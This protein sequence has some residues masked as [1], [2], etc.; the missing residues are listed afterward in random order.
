MSLESLHETSEARSWV[1][2]TQ[3]KS[4]RI[5]YFTDDPDYQPPMQG[6]WYY[7]SPFEGTL[8]ESMTLRNCWRW[9]FN[10]MEF[11]DAGLP[12]PAKRDASLLQGNK[13]ALLEL[14][15]QR[16]DAIR[17]PLEPSSLAGADLRAHKLA[18]ARAVLNHGSSEVLLLSE[19]AAAH[20]CSVDEMARRVTEHDRRRTEVL[21]RT[22]VQ[23]EA[24]AAAIQRA[25]T[26]QE[27][28]TLRARIVDEV[29]A[30]QAEQK[31]HSPENTTPEKLKKPLD[32]GEL[33]NEQL[34]LRV[35]L[36]NRINDLRRPYMSQYVLDDYVLGR[37]VEIAAAVQRAGGALPP[38][39]DG[40]LLLSHAAARG[41]R[42]VEAAQ[43][44]LGESRD[45][46]SA[47]VM[48]EQMKDAMLARIVSAGTL[49]DIRE[50]GRAIERLALSDR[51]VQAV[52][53]SKEIA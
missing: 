37:K 9:R 45:I 28:M 32:A 13:Q 41:Q 42:L 36:R 23:R 12:K 47:L 19:V 44:V 10:G 30:E 39:L 40:T 24:I 53:A 26:Q 21:L 8:P 43:D 15:S 2:V 38:G 29:A 27:L 14:L 3:V 48:T 5:V 25:T 17:R 31:P 52:E 51:A 16:I 6:D 34:R 49:A 46:R 7:V 18:E 35:Q 22:E 1:V 11:V 4:H 33:A 50:T 20:L